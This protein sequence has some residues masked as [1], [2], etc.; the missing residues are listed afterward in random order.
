MNE[1]TRFASATTHDQFREIAQLAREI[2]T[3][4]YTPIIGSAQVAYMLDK[5][6]SEAAIKEQVDEGVLY[7][8][9][10]YDGAPAG[11]VSVYKKNTALFLSKFYVHKSMRGKGIGKLA[12]GLVQQKAV[13]MDCDRIALTVNKHNTGSIK[14]Y[15][16]L[17]F[18]NKGPVV[19]DI[20]E[21]FI[22]DD[23]AFE[24]KISN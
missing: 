11:Y 1:K 16:K 7:Y 5:F 22:M 24:K 9:I 2:W 6:Q 19:I 18:E 10:K 4:H 20:G 21:G 14:A 8:L 3:E 15:D 23:F 17:G 12:L 13:E